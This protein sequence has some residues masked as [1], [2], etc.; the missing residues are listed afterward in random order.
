MD[1]TGSAAGRV[2]VL[3]SPILVGNPE[4]LKEGVYHA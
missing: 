2:F 1:P 4:Q 3:R